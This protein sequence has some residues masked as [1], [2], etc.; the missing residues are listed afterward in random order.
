M[1]KLLPA[2]SLV[3]LLGACATDP[4]LRSPDPAD[5]WEGFNRNVYAMNRTLDKAI[6]KPVAQGYKAVMPQPLR[7]GISNGM[8]NLRAPV[9]LVNEWLQGKFSESAT[10]LGRFLLNSIFGIGGLFDVASR[11]GIPE[12]DED[13]GQT[14]AAWGW[15]NSNYLVIPFLGP[16]T[17]RD[18]VGL[19]PEI[20]TSGVS[21]ISRYADV[22]WFIGVDVINLRYELLPQEDTLKDASDEYLLVR[23]AYL[24]RR[25]F[26][27]TDGESELPDYDEYLFDEEEFEEDESADAGDQ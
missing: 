11:E 2:L 1:K 12:Y 21:I 25:E 7:Q 18:G 27:I 14:F 16:S 15:N 20:W 23:D 24:Q 17:L 6:V 5:P 3:A 22:T 26:L 19:V 10:T 4:S 8:R 9:T 13:F